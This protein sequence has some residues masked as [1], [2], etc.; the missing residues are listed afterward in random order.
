MTPAP[1]VAGATAAKLQEVAKGLTADLLVLGGKVY[2][3]VE[4][5]VPT[6]KKTKTGRPRYVTGYRLEP[7]DVELHVNPLAIG[8]GVAGTAIGAVLLFGRYGNV[9]K[10]PLADEFEATKKEREETRKA[11]EG[12][13]TGKPTCEELKREHDAN[14]WNPFAQG[15]IRL[16]A[17]NQGCEWVKPR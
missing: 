2:R 14:W 6:G 16:A 5:R 7:V 3:R 4:E 8:L 12:R 15:I 13:P 9:Y 1:I 11:R 10:G 17:W